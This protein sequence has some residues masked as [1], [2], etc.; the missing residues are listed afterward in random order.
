MARTGYMFLLESD[1]ELMEV[2]VAEV[3]SIEEAIGRL[4]GKYNF[5]EWRIINVSETLIT[6]EELY[7]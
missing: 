1:K 7:A 6:N 3:T 4:R 5:S 2:K